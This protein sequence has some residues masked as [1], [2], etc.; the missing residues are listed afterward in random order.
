MLH[1]E[2]KAFQISAD[3][4][5]L[6]LKIQL[7]SLYLVKFISARSQ[8]I[9]SLISLSN[10]KRNLNSNNKKNKRKKLQKSNQ[11]KKR[12]RKSHPGKIY[13]LNQLLISLTTKL[14]LSMLRIRKKL[15]NNFGHNGITMVSHSGMYIIKNT[16]V[17]VSNF[18]LPTIL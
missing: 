13:C 9:Q 4:V 8:S 16:M 2:K 3:I 17:R 10:K 1:T 12:K 7:S 11:R 14:L 6:F 15:F 18:T 5:K